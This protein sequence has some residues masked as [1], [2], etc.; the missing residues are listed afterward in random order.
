[1]PSPDRR[2]PSSAPR[3]CT[4]RLA[5]RSA[6]P[7]ATGGTR[8]WRAGAALAAAAAL[9][10]C[11]PDAAT[12]PGRL[13]PE[14]RRPAADVANLPTT[15]PILHD[16]RSTSFGLLGVGNTGGIPAYMAD[17]FTVPASASWAVAQVAISGLFYK[18]D[19]ILTFAVRADD[20]GVPGS[21]VAA[22]ILSPSASDP[23]SAVD[24]HPRP[25]PP[26]LTLTDYLFTLPAPVTL[27]PGT[28]WLTVVSS[29][30][31][32]S[33]VF[34]WQ[35]APMV[36]GAGGVFSRDGGAT[37]RPVTDFGLAPTDFAF[38]LFGTAQPVQAPAQLIT[39]L[40]ATV[41]GLGLHQGTARSLDAKL[42]TALAAV[43][44]GDT[45][46]ACTALQD[47]LDFVAAQA[48]KKIPTDQAAELSDDLSTI[49]TSLGCGA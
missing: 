1:M 43:E 23:N 25:G 5:P 16:Q 38:V 7:R 34:G 8:A 33:V 26:T 22:F 30:G 19:N 13:T 4:P 21:E 6:A 3:A 49:R 45:A 17:D 28:Y 24:P 15:A 10:G 46:G 36:T 32:H 2:F 39:A 48:G 27:A 14:G 35:T 31:D 37:W 12:A 41:A 20:A 47:A 42:R 40:Q 11:A 29:I 9:A 18:A 44:A